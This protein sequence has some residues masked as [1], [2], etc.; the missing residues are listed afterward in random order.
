MFDAMNNA[1]AASK[2]E[3]AHDDR[4]EFKRFLALF[5]AIF[6]LNQDTLLEWHY[7]GNVRW[8]EN[9]G[10]SYLPYMTVIDREAGHTLWPLASPLTPSNDSLS[11][12]LQQPYYKLHGSS[13]WFAEPHGARMLIMG[14]NKASSI[15]G[16]SI[17]ARYMEEFRKRLLLPETRLIV[18]GYSFGDKHI[19]D[20]I[21]AGVNRET[22]KLFIVDPQGVDVLNK[23]GPQEGAPDARTLR[24]RLFQG[25]YGASRRQL[26]SIFTNDKV[27]NEK[28]FSFFD[29]SVFETRISLPD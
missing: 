19:N 8:S 2:L 22:L 26:R 6:T 20:A 1:F 24:D 21:Q 17:L 28:L 27:E 4:H 25:L 29:R 5:D 13:N 11:S 14:T 7:L 16:S 9:W 18:I 3:F 15:A 10:G 12:D 23:V